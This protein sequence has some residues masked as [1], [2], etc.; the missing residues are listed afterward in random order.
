MHDKDI[1]TENRKAGFWV[2]FAAIWIDLFIIWVVV[3]IAVLLFNYFDIYVPLELAVG[4]SMLVY[5]VILIGWRG[6]TVG[7]WLCGL[8]VQS[9]KGKPV[10]YIRAFLRETIGKF[11]STVF[12]FLGFAWVA[13]SR[14]KRGWH[15]YIVQTIVKQDIT[16]IKRAR[17][18]LAAVLVANT[19]FL[20]SKVFVTVLRYND[21]MKMAVGPN[22]T[23]TYS[24]RD[25]SSLVEVS[26]LQQTDNAAFVNWLDENGK[27]PVDY[28]VEVARKHQITIFGEVH[29]IQDDL[30][31]LNRI[32]PELYHRAGVT[33][34]AME[35]LTMEDNAKLAKLVTSEQFD[36]GLALQIARHQGWQAWGGKEY[37]DV[38]ETVWRLN[39]TLPAASKK[40]RLVGLDFKW[41]GPS[42]GMVGTGDDCAGGP[43]WEKLRLL[44]LLND[45][46]LLL[47]RDE[48]MA[49]NVEK[50]IVEKGERAI[51][52][53]GLNHDYI[54]Y[55]QARI[56]NGKVFSEWGRMG[57]ML[58]QKY[59]D[60]VFHIRLHTF[61]NSP[62]IAKLIEKIAAE[63]ENVP[64]GFDVVGSPFALLRNSNSGYFRFRP[65][66]CFSDVA[67]G[68]VYLKPKNKLKRCEWLSGYISRE[69]FVKNKPFYEAECGHK[70]NNAKE[71]NKGIA[72]KYKLQWTE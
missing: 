27:D 45:F 48:V 56:I 4:L 2:R 51:V 28:V 42:F 53:V 20:G 33:C 22:V 44:R 70:L 58:H 16:T 1:V 49:R 54:N 15:D 61:F 37:W 10:G 66:V 3:R 36:G 57:F 63:R 23:T 21:A 29:H 67:S 17:W 19:M 72:S 65:G 59:G 30:L 12:L 13:F 5:S 14:K 7:K 47:K 18:L 55:R 46:P 31:F 41:D 26:S 35:A 32:I 39:Q 38:F 8:T 25:P 68:Y 64:V 71:A 34:I 62:K 40:M 69:M 9:S 11:L 24:Q 52:W 43:P 60:K 6:S 50:Q